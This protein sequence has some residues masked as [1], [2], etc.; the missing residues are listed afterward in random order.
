[1]DTN[2]QFIKDIAKTLNWA[3]LFKDPT[4]IS[5]EMTWKIYSGHIFNNKNISATQ[6]SETKQAYY[7]GFSECFRMMTDLS[8]KLPESQAGSILSKLSRECNTYVESL[9][10]RKI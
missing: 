4:K 1:M 9:I 8:T 10:E 6:Y 7:V 2:K 3:D 5:V